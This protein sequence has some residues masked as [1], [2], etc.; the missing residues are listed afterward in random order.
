MV[1]WLFKC[2]F[3]GWTASLSPTDPSPHQ[4]S[5]KGAMVKNQSSPLLLP[6]NY[7]TM[8]KPALRIFAS[9]FKLHQSLSLNGKRMISIAHCPMTRRSGRLYWKQIFLTLRLSSLPE[10]WLLRLKGTCGPRYHGF[11]SSAPANCAQGARKQT[12][13]ECPEDV[14]KHC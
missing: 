14:T 6:F 10:D 13:P 5:F 1:L 3:W 11:T 8:E 12:S 2:G 7:F 9:L 4:N